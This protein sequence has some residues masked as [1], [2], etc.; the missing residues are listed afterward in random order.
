MSEELLGAQHNEA[1]S[2]LQGIGINQISICSHCQKFEDCKFENDDIGSCSW[3]A[4]VE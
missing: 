4:G 2:T 3:F 1:D